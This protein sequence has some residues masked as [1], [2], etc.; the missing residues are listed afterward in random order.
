MLFSEML[1]LGTVMHHHVPNC[2]PKILVCCLQGRGHS[3][4]SYHKRWLSNISS[5]LPI[6]LQVNYF[7]LMASMSWVVLWKDWIALLWWRSRSQERF[8]IPV[9][10]HVN[11]DYY[12]LNRRT[13]CNQSGYGDVP[14]WT[15]VSCKKMDLQPSSSRSQWGRI[16]SNISLFLTN[17]LNCIYFYTQI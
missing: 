1:K 9:N 7:G 8:R 16:W 12:L 17:I 11:Y 13:V 3:K 2:L 10:A 4:E 6:L 15:R 14:S 5:E